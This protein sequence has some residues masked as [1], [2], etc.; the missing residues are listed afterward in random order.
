MKLVNSKGRVLLEVCGAT[1]DG[2]DAN[3]ALFGVMY[4]YRGHGISGNVSIVSLNA[5]IEAIKL[6][7]PSAKLSGLLPEPK[8]PAPKPQ[9]GALEKIIAGEQVSKEEFDV[10]MNN[11]EAALSSCRS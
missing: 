7:N 9:K 11:L 4:Q 8:M 10:A 6:D 5:T 1:A 2:L 3:G